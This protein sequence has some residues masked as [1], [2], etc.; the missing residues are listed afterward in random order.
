M[1]LY[2]EKSLVEIDRFISETLEKIVIDGHSLSIQEILSVACDGASVFF[3]TDDRI[4]KRVSESYE[5]M[6]K[7]VIDGVPVYGCNTGYGARASHVVNQGE[8]ESRLAFAKKISESIVHT[9]VTVG[10]VLSKEVVRA[11][12][13][14]RIN[15]LLH[16]V[17][18]VKIS[19]LDIIRQLLN[20]GITP[21]VNAYGGLGASGDLAHNSRVV[22]VLRQLKGTFVFDKEGHKRDAAEVLREH[23]IPCLVLDPKAGLGLVNGDNF[24]TAAA[25]LIVVEV[26][27][28]QLIADVLGAMMVEVLKGSTRPFHPFLAKV[29][30][31]DGQKE[32][33]SVYRYL[34]EGSRLAYQEL[35]GQKERPTG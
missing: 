35:T 26:L 34:L 14:I 3:T 29:R 4:L 7:N 25:T 11:A 21:V 32:T 22:S 13:L 9:D 5:V 8:K 6:R 28:L 30:P 31:H 19:D 17:S 10:P 20:E 24:S 27:R 2:K 1:N 18:A 12:M 23:N 15:M 16:G 33:A